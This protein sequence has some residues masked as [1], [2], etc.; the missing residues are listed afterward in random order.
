MLLLGINELITDS[1]VVRFD[2]VGV[3]AYADKVKTT[4]KNANKIERFFISLTP[5]EIVLFRRYD[6]NLNR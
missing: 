2:T 3:C 5:F 1:T 6:R 4:H